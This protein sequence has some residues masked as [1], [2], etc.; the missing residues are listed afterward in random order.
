V[1][2]LIIQDFHCERENAARFA[3]L[4]LRLRKDLKSVLVDLQA[5][6]F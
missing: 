6:D 5:L 1:E 3:E 2:I 4:G